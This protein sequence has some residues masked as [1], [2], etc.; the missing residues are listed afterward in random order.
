MHNRFLSVVAPLL[1]VSV[2]A[3]AGEPAAAS[4]TERWSSF[5]P[6]WGEEARERGHD[7]PLPFGFGANF[8]KIWQNYD[9]KSVQLNPLVPVPFPIDGVEASTAEGK[10]YSLDGRLDVWLL[11][12]LNIYGV[13]G[14][15]EGES[16]ATATIPGLGN[17]RFPFV[18]N[19]EG[20]TYGGGGTLAWG[21]KQLFAS[22]DYNYTETQLD[23][24]DSRIT[25]HVFT[26]RLGWHGKVGKVKGAAW[27][28]TMY[29]DIVQSF[30]GALDVILPGIPGSIPVRYQVDERPTN[31][32][33]LIM[34][35][36]WQISRHLHF[37]VEGGVVGREQILSSLTFRF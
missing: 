17:L 23:I 35:L 13:A 10:G 9:I 37:V 31:P 19:Y 14:Y 33:N 2:P 25:A 11:P 29:Q 5:L 22:L 26:P 4:E 20:V 12:F 8:M 1:L 32:W 28:G 34:G 24:A 3:F 15:T 21:Y 36:E 18:L 30:R 7:L 6:L 27:L 16:R